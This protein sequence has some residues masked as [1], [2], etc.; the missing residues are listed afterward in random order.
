MLRGRGRVTDGF[1]C[2]EKG[3]TYIRQWRRGREEIWM[4]LGYVFALTVIEILNNLTTWMR[5]DMCMQDVLLAGLYARYHS[6]SQIRY[7]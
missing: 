3:N 1:S 6:R 7:H 5:S 4:G 2:T